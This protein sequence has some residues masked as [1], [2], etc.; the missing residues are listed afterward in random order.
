MAAGMVEKTFGWAESSTKP[1]ED[2]ATTTI[3]TKTV[4]IKARSVLLASTTL[5]AEG[6]LEEGASCKDRLQVRDEGPRKVRRRLKQY[7][8]DGD[9][10]AILESRRRDAGSSARLHVQPVLVLGLRSSP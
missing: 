10:P 5:A 7:N 8:L 1:I 4:K 3:S 2:E 9:A 6:E